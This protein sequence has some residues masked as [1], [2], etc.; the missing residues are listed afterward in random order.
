MGRYLA[1]V[2]MAL[3]LAACGGGGGGALSLDPVASAA[4]KT[5]KSGGEHMT[6]RVRIR[7]PG[8]GP[9]LSITG[10]GDFDAA[11]HVGR[12]SLQ[13]SGLPQLRGP[14]EEI[15][16]GSVVYVR[17]P[18]LEGRLPSG[19]HWLKLDLAKQARAMGVDFNALQSSTS[20]PTQMVR[21]LEAASTGVEKIGPARVAGAAT[22]HYSATVDFDKLAR[23]R[24][25]EKSSIKRL[26]QLTGVKYVPVDVWIDRDHYVR[27]VKES[28][29]MHLLGPG[30][31]TTR[32][33]MSY[34]LSGFGTHV[35]ASPPPGNEVVDA[36]SLGGA[37]S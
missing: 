34:E 30:G 9:S 36:S 25:N 23:A 15:L 32:M 37:A 5:A 33:V 28:I 19:K 6:F 12:A 3:A 31:A 1:L 26:E 13:F 24:P 21:Y 11:K 20:D 10:S 29:E 8:P 18:F 22:T 35:D 27:R 4:T 2:P 7:P 16:D 17:F 14:A